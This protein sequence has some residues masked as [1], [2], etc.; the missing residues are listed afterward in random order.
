MREMINWWRG[1]RAVTLAKSLLLG[2]LPL[3][4]CLVY[5]I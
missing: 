3:T 4:C 1:E 5:R 2:L